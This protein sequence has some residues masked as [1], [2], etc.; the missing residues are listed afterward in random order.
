M[1][2]GKGEERKEMKDE[3]KKR[4]RSEVEGDWSMKGEKKQREEESKRG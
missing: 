2:Q 3:V 4:W 1:S